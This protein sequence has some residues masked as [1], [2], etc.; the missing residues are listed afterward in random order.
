VLTV[1]VPAAEAVSGLVKVVLRANVN[2]LPP[3]VNVPEE[4]KMSLIVRVDPAKEQVAEVEAGLVAL[5]TEHAL[6][7]TGKSEGNTISITLSE[8]SE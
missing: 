7:A 8:G 6:F 4:P 1:K 5:V 3:L 2:A